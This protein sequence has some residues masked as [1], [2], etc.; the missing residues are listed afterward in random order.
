M[1]AFARK[2]EELVRRNLMETLYKSKGNPIRNP[3]EIQGEFRNL[4]GILYKS[5]GEPIRMFLEILQKSNGNLLQ[6][7]R[8]PH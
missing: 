5:K 7:Q 6:T 2:M 1:E 4:M 8:E 3:L